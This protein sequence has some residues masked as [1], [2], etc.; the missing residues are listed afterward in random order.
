MT[1]RYRP[2]SRSSAAHARPGSRRLIGR[3]TCS[4]TQRPASR[5]SAT[6]TT[7]NSTV[8][9]SCTRWHGP[10]GPLWTVVRRAACRRTSA[11]QAAASASGR[12]SP[13]MSTA[14]GMLY[15][16]R[17][18]PRSCSSHSRR[19]LGASGALVA[20]L[21]RAIGA[22]RSARS[23]RTAS[24][25]AVGWSSTWAVGRSTPNS[26]RMSAAQAAAP[27]ESPPDSKKS[28]STPGVAPSRRAASPA[29][30]AA[31]PA[32]ACRT[33]AGASSGPGGYAVRRAA[34][35]SL[36][37]GVTGRSPTTRRYAGT[38]ARGSTEPAYRRM[39]AGSTGAPSV[40]GTT[41]AAIA[42]RSP[43]RS[44]ST[45]AARRSGWAA[46]ATCTSSRLSRTPLTLTRSSTR[47]RKTS[48]PSG[49]LVTRSPLRYRREPG[50]PVSEG[51]KRSAVAA[52]SPRYPRANWSP[53]RYSSPSVAGRRSAS[54]TS[55]RVE[56][57]G[58]PIG[59]PPSTLP[60]GSGS[61]Q[62]LSM[63]VSVSP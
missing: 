56:A 7:G 13:V 6:V 33:C 50:G 10:S 29:R 11:R 54:R 60:P 24:A 35:S 16:A 27:S 9:S 2:G 38:A 5:S 48:T 1:S 47:R 53:L 17:S 59:T 15:A 8:R 63:A 26:A 37:L 40:A 30:T 3:A 32:P 20:P 14:T 43:M 57:M 23:T 28:S 45:A 4:S 41:Q 36:P 39:A 42:S 22:R 18:S 25:A 34:R 55:T 49:R 61:C 44:T 21:S 12:R 52:G 62:V 58:R 46:T 31:V 51:T 19:W